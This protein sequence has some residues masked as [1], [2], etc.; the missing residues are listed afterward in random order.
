[1]PNFRIETLTMPAA[2]LGGENPLPRLRP[3]LSAT[4][5]VEVDDSVPHFDRTH[6][7]YGLDAGWL[8]HR[9]QDDYDRNRRDRG[10]LALVLENEFLR[11]TIL[12][13]VGGRLW[14]LVHRPSG[15][16]LLHVNTVFQPANL[17]VRGAWVAGGVEWNA[18]VYGHSPYNCSSVFAALVDDPRAGVIVRVFEWD[19]TRCVPYQIDFALPDGSPVLLVRVRLTNP[20]SHTIPMYWWSNIAVPESPDVRVIVPADSAYTYEYWGCVHSVDI[21]RESN[22]DITYP[23]NISHAGDYFYRISAGARPWIAALDRDGRGLIQT[24]TAR[25]IGRKLFAWGSEPGGRRW[26]EFLS[27]PGHPYFEIQAGLAR[28]QMECTPMPSSALWEWVEAYGLLEADSRKVHGLDWTDAVGEVSQRLEQCISQC[29]LEAYL[30]QSSESAD[31]PPAEIIHRGSGWGALERRRREKCG[32]RPFCSPALA[33]DD[34]SLTD[35]QQP[36]LMLLQNGVFPNREPECEPGAWMVQNEWQDL[37]QSGMRRRAGDHWLALL[38]LGVMHYAA[39]NSAAADQAWRLSLQRRPS[40][41]AY[42]NLAM[43]RRIEGRPDDAL[44]L[45]RKAMALMPELKPLLIEFLGVLHAVG[46]A[47]EAITILEAAPLAIREHSRVFVLRARAGLALGLTQPCL[48]ILHESFEL[49]DIRE[50]ETTLTDLWRAYREINANG[51]STPHSIPTHLNFQVMPDPPAG[52]PAQRTGQM[53]RSL[54]SE[55]ATVQS[56]SV[57]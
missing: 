9:G 6:F 14:S 21:P 41:W 42:R 8:P 39:G 18:C 47:G 54:Q 34:E 48:P 32:E 4:A 30:C 3:R 50:G 38:H 55:T 17:A 15:R 43:L 33:F 23:T 52:S 11:A 7:G 49:V 24:S 27:P 57:V 1:M 53:L 31:R 51:H 19:R 10:F 40:G 56:C 22:V 26:Q 35:D 13:E 25:Q 5:G 45:Y 44:E 37:L 36:W 20:H 46:H 2:N 16:E 28:T 29:E 12:P